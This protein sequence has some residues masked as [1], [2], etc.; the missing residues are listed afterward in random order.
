MASVRDGEQQ[1]PLPSGWRKHRTSLGEQN[2]KRGT[3]SPRAEHEHAQ[4]NEPVPQRRS[5]IGTA[6]R[7]A[8]EFVADELADVVAPAALVRGY[9]PRAA[10]LF[11]RE[12]ANEVYLIPWGL[13]LLDEGRVFARCAPAA[14][15]SL[16]A[17]ETSA[18]G[19]GP[20]G[21]IREPGASARLASAS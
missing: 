7:F 11:L 15:L 17:P 8:D 21:A 12:Q 9:Q 1:L 20:D 10:T 5:L 6:V 14:A 19:A 13:T 16:Q 2:G 18:V 3:S 4:R